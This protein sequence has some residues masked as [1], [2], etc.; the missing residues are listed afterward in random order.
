MATI[1]IT[2]NGNTITLQA[3]PSEQSIVDTSTSFEALS[4]SR[5]ASVDASLIEY[6]GDARVTYNNY[7]ATFSTDTGQSEESSYTFIVDQTVPAL[8]EIDTADQSSAVGILIQTEDRYSGTE[9]VFE[10]HIVTAPAL[11]E[12]INADAD[13]DQVVEGPD[14][15]DEGLLSVGSKS[16]A[17][18]GS[19]KPGSEHPVVLALS[20]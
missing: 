17:L 16:K 13:L 3:Q 18:R 1:D 12:S 6:A 7:T 5:P 2:G 14:A 4:M 10:T 9:Y 8:T 20:A 15:A 19:S 11:V